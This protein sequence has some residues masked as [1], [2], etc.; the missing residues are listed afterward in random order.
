LLLGETPHKVWELGRLTEVEAG[1]LMDQDLS[2][3]QPPMGAKPMTPE[4]IEEYRQ[5]RRSLTWRDKWE[6]A[7]REW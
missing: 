4:E 6:M 5:W 3:P 2:K 1:F 7:V